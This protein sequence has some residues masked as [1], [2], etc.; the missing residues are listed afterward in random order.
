M[1]DDITYAIVKNWFEQAIHQLSGNQPHPDTFEFVKD[2]YENR[3]YHNLIHV[4]SAIN[5]IR[6][7]PIGNYDEYCSVVLALIFHD[8]YLDYKITDSKSVEESAELMYECLVDVLSRA[9]LKVITNLILA[10]GPRIPRGDPQ[11]KLHDA[12]YAILGSYHFDSYKYYSELVEEE[13]LSHGIDKETFNK[14]RIEFLKQQLSKPNIYYTMDFGN[15]YEWK[16]RQ[17]IAREIA[18]RTSGDWYKNVY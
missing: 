11:K 5:E 16:A 3:K 14:R 8:I 6:A 18:L 15:K 4:Y 9:Q 13:V 12:D 1:T 2:M 10:T 7:F 17:N